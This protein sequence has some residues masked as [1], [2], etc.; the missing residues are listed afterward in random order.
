MTIR[1]QWF[2]GLSTSVLIT[3][4]ITV[5]MFVFVANQIFMWYID[6]MYTNEKTYL[7]NYVTEAMAE[8]NYDEKMLQMIT[9]NIVNP[10]SKIEI[11]DQSGEVISSITNETVNVD[12]GTSNHVTEQIDLGVINES[13]GV[14]SIV[15]NES[16]SVYSLLSPFSG[17][18]LKGFIPCVLVLLM[19]AGA[20][21][22]FMSQKTAAQLEGLKEGTTHNDAMIWLKHRNSVQMVGDFLYRSKQPLMILKK[23]FDGDQAGRINH[24]NEEMGRCKKQIAIVSQLMSHVDAL[25][26]SDLE[27]DLKEEAFNFEELVEQI[28]AAIENKYKPKQFEI[29]IDIPEPIIMLGDMGKISQIIYHLVSNAFK[30]TPGGGQIHIEAVKIDETLTICVRDSGAGISDEEQGHIFESHF[31]GKLGRQYDGDGMGLYITF[32]NIVA[33]NGEIHV[34]SKPDEGSVFIVS[35]PYIPPH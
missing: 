12:D 30:F 13:G 24:S 29:N 6:A 25:I 16:L 20:L 18:I 34:R 19:I 2:L 8:G 4:L 32:E 23:H 28:V 26:K 15:K 27:L 10:I 7:V 3:L 1:K 35:I 31:Q 17:M 5:G 9:S 22:F 11:L 33:L 21:G 14:I